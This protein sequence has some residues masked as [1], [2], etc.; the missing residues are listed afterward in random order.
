M[1]A[2]STLVRYEGPLDVRE[3][4]AIS[5]FLA[6]YAGNTRIRYSRAALTSSPPFLPAPPADH[7]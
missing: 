7:P 5:G 2:T 1:A 4:G 3:R 6:G